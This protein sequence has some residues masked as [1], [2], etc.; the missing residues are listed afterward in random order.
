MFLSLLAANSLYYACITGLLVVAWH[1]LVWR[2]LAFDHFLVSYFVYARTSIGKF[3]P[4]NVGHFVG[5]QLVAKRFGLSQSMVATG[6]LMEVFCQISAALLICV[7]IDWQIASAF[8]MR[9]ALGLCIVGLV[10]APS[11][12]LKVGAFLRWEWIDKVERKSLW[13]TVA[14][15][16]FIDMLFFMAT[17]LIVVVLVYYIAP[18][19]TMGVMSLIA[20]YTVAWLLGTITPGAPAGLGVREAIFLTMLEPVLGGESALAVSIAFRIVCTL[21]DA[22]F[23]ASSY[24]ISGSG[25]ESEQR[26]RDI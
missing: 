14:V 6:T 19:H 15:S 1:F 8:W 2:R 10:L 3:L 25:I 21:G 16:S 24:F 22:F 5:R 17:G 26:K 4:G 7:W 9:L 12:L 18:D 20:V 11:L 23:F 13:T